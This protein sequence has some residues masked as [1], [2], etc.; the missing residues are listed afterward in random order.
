MWG[1]VWGPCGK[2]VPPGEVAD[3]ELPG[4][5]SGWSVKRVAPWWQETLEA[6]RELMQ[7]WSQARSEHSSM[8]V[9]PQ[10]E[11]SG[12]SFRGRWPGRHGLIAQRDTCA[13]WSGALG[14]VQSRLAANLRP[15][16]PADFP[17]CPHELHGPGLEATS[18]SFLEVGRVGI[19]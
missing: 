16:V 18:L 19:F 3:G 7:A 10:G 15:L 11:R 17:Y 6:A 9:G 13:Q 4:L 2:R 1:A 8:S 14:S 5:R 12:G